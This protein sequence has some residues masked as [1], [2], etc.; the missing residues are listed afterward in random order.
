MCFYLFT[1]EILPA[2]VT[3]RAAVSLLITLDIRVAIRLLVVPFVAVRGTVASIG[4]PEI[5]VL[6]GTIAVPGHA[7]IAAIVH[8]ILIAILRCRATAPI[9]SIGAVPVAA[10]AIL[11]YAIVA[12]VIIVAIMV[13]IPIV[14]SIAIPVSVMMITVMVV[15]IVVSILLPIPILVL[16]NRFQRMCNRKAAAQCQCQRPRVNFSCSHIDTLPSVTRTCAPE[17]KG[18]SLSLVTS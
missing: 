6:L 16:R 8:A 3:S 5:A 4:V 2:A 13:A 1:V 17:F 7:I 11:A 14:V 9:P 15:P 10:V 18:N 12:P